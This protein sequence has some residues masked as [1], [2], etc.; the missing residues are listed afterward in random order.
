MKGMICKV[1]VE[2]ILEEKGIEL[3]IGIIGQ[4]RNCSPS[5]RASL[6]EK[7]PYKKI[8]RTAGRKIDSQTKPG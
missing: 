7:P 2:E 3:C 6:I 1:A 5:T 8:E 4:N